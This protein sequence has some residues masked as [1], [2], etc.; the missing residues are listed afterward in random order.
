MTVLGANFQVATV[1]SDVGVFVKSL[2]VY[3][4]AGWVYPREK[5]FSGAL[6]WKLAQVAEM[7]F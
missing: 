5:Q 1:S 3:E 7:F 2:N 4:T 6:V